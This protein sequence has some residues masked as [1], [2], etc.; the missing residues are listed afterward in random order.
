MSSQLN[1]FSEKSELFP[2][3]PQLFFDLGAHITKSC[4]TQQTAILLEVSASTLY[5]ARQAGNSYSKNGWTAK[6]LGPNAWH[7]IFQIVY[8]SEAYVI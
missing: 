6:P 8:C 4:T 2:R 3:A 1:L 5:R 7:V